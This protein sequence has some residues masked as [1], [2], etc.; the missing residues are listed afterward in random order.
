MAITS[1][2]N[3]CSPYRDRKVLITGAT[4][5]IGAPLCRRLIENG[6]EVYAVSR[7][8][9]QPIDRLHWL[10]ADPADL[11]KLR[12]ILNDT[13]PDTIFHLA[14]LS[15]AAT[16]LQLVLPTFHSLL[17]T[18]VYL[19]AT[20]AELGCSRI[21]LAGSL[22]EPAPSDIDPTPGSPYAAAKWAASAYGRMFFKLYGTPVV[23]VR[24]F[25][26][27]GP[28]QRANK[29]VPYVILAA[30][31]GEVPKVSSGQWEAD[32]IYIDDVVDGF[33]AA[34]YTPG[35]DGMTIDLGSGALTSV[36]AVVQ[37]IIELTDER[38]Q[39]VFGAQRD[40]P[41]EKVRVAETDLAYATLRW[42]ATT[43]VNEGLARTVEW[44]RH[45]L[46]EDGPL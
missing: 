40:R 31:R 6:A 22:T 24:P 7:S 4:G 46:N 12:Q 41:Y 36:R 17:A 25:M 13:K 43:S 11:C 14:G 15:T 8:A 44:L 9:Q 23:M 1:S 5:F 3:F 28:G 26:A 45:Q 20:A 39:P 37:K 30:L 35:I 34:G 16:D 2:K 27:Y 42:K 21:V 33:L 32:W 18:T 10:Q 29:L 38:V 19:L